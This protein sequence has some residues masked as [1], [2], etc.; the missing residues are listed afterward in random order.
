[1]KR[2]V[3]AGIAAAVCG[4]ALAMS[5]NEETKGMDPQPY[6]SGHKADVK[7]KPVPGTEAVGK[8]APG[9]PEP[10]KGKAAVDETAGMDPQHPGGSKP[11]K[12]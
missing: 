11:V 10:L 5:P 2:I 4:V 3:I 8:A 9:T 1:M 12:K 6:P 7:K